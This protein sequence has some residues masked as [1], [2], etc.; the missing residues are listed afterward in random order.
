[1]ENWDSIKRPRA[2]RHLNQEQATD[3]IGKAVPAGTKLWSKAGWT[4]TAR[5][6]AAYVELPNGN[7]LVLVIFTTGHSE[8]KQIIPALAR[9]IFDATN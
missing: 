3:Y 2:H 8:D 5:H 4:S 9:R 6:D 1:M 7:K